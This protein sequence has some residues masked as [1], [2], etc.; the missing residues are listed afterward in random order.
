[1]NPKALD[2]YVEAR[3]HLDQAGKLDLYK[4]KQ[5]LLKEELRKATYYLD[6]AIQED[7]AYIPAYVAYFDAVNGFTPQLEF[8]PRAKAALQKA[9]EVDEANVEAHLAF[10]TLLMQY[11]YDWAG[12][13]TEYKRAIEINPNSAEAHVDYAE[14]LDNVEGGLDNIGDTEDAK[15]ERELAQA[16][17]PAHD[18]YASAGM[19]RLGRRNLDQERQALEEQAAHDPFAI[20]AMA[21]DYALAGRYK[22]AVEMYERCVNLYGWNDFAEVLNRGNAKGGAKYALQEWM[23]AAEEY[24]RTHD[25]LPVVTM[26]FTYSSLGD[27]DRAFTWLEKAV[28]QRSWL[29]LYLK[30]D[31]A[32]DPLRSDPRFASLLRRVGLPT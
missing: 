12:A 15:R 16:L 17:D 2:A 22:E 23:R 11:E 6:R 10:G 4:G 9:M 14:Y 25:D 28:E 32:W 5:G 1:V 19:Q 7:P 18:Y 26:A 24:S 13:E 27:K 21:K 30:R 3:F 29:I 8:L 20:G 31:N